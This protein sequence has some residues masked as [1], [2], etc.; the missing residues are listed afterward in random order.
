AAQNRHL[1][2]GATESPS[3]PLLRADYRIDRG[4]LH[5]NPQL[6][7][8]C[9]AV[10]ALAN[11]ASQSEDRDRKQ[12]AEEEKEKCP[13]EQDRDEIAPRDDV[14]GLEERQ[15]PRS[16]AGHCGHHAVGSDSI[17]SAC[18]AASP[19]MATNASW[20]PA[21]SIDSDRMPAPPSI[22]ACSRGSTPLS[23]SAKCQ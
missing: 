11:A 3:Q 6:G 23:G 5:C 10:D 1:G 14:G 16:C 13:A 2:N 7:V 17:S 15:S 21:R 18:A 19:A 20:S 9:R 4:T 12:G 8:R 22:S